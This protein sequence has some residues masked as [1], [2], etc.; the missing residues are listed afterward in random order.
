MD[1]LIPLSL[2]KEDKQFLLAANAAAAFEKANEAFQ[3]DFG[4]PIGLNSAYRSVE[5][6]KALYL[7]LRGKQA[8]APPG[9]SEHNYGR[10][11]DVQDW[12]AAKPYLE[13]VGFKWANHKND[14]W[15]YDFKGAGGKPSGQQ[16]QGALDVGMALPAPVD[17]FTPTLPTEGQLV[18]PAPKVPSILPA[19]KPIDI[20]PMLS[21]ATGIMGQSAPMPS[22]I[23]L[24]DPVAEARAQASS[25]VAT[26]GQQFAR[27][28]EPPKTNFV[29]DFFSHAANA[30]TGYTQDQLLQNS[31]NGIGSM[32]G[33]V[34]GGLVPIATGTAAG[35]GLGALSLTPFGVGAGAVGGGIASAGAASA[36]Q[37]LQAQR[38]EGTQ[39][40]NLLR[41]AGAAGV[42]ALTQ[43][44]PIIK[45]GSILS[46]LAKNAAVQG[47]AGGAGAIAQQGFEQGRIIPNVDWNRVGAQAALGAAGGTVGAGS[48]YA[49]PAVA[50]NLEARTD[51]RNYEAW[52]QS[53]EPFNRY[54]PADP[55]N[56]T[57]VRVDSGP[58]VVSSKTP[59]TQRFGVIDAAQVN[60]P[61]GQEVLYNSRKAAADAY[62]VVKAQDPNFVG[63]IKQT[64]DGAFVIH[65]R[66]ET[67]TAG[68]QV[69]PAPIKPDPIID[70]PSSPQLATEGSLTSQS[71][72]V[73]SVARGV[74]VL[75]APEPLK[76]RLP[77]PTPLVDAPTQPVQISEGKPFTGE[78]LPPKPIQPPEPQA[79]QTKVTPEQKS[80]I[81]TGKAITPEM[82]QPN[83][84]ATTAKVSKAFAEGK[85]VSTSDGAEVFVGKSPDK[86]QAALSDLSKASDE[87]GSMKLI[88]FNE[89]RQ[90]VQEYL[91]DKMPFF[92]AFWQAGTEGK[93]LIT[94]YR[95][96][97]RG[98]A[99][100]TPDDFMHR[101]AEGKAPSAESF[102][103]KEQAL[104]A[105]E[106]HRRINPTHQ[107][108]DPY[109]VT[110]TVRGK[111]K[112]KWQVD[113]VGDRQ[114]D[115][116]A[117]GLQEKNGEPYLYL[118]SYN[119]SSTK[120]GN[121]RGYRLG[122]MNET[123]DGFNASQI[124]ANSPYGNSIQAIQKQAN[125]L[126]QFVMDSLPTKHAIPLLAD[127]DSGNFP[128][129][130]AKLRKAM[131]GMNYEEAHQ[132]EAALKAICKL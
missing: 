48:E 91:P 122:R 68:G 19:P 12:E 52:L 101:Y 25:D 60:H 42:G 69:L 55:S 28:P 75:P 85:L 132:L 105:A 83:L 35:A 17:P 95:E 81:D 10:A 22:P 49:I 2:S 64:P 90:L 107:V 111:E 21:Q 15:H 106:A 56:P 82:T 58:V 89:G 38:L 20:T 115:P 5:E 36:A 16:P 3:M 92:E 117:I 18:V 66:N 13:A 45:G 125:E 34:A 72:D 31:G 23:R 128:A 4:R 50:K 127:V 129:A 87:G 1:G 14:P 86:T 97:V 124:D 6:Q 94:N 126:R 114:I 47:A 78:P 33:D 57:P 74:D 123:L 65:G 61:N 27:P 76:P 104:V 8:V 43:A 80:L 112:T 71:P 119:Y 79:I 98:W 9:R 99:K 131:K 84:E 110:V 62:N 70:S 108:S 54:V 44:I 103:T 26:V 32:L 40:P 100:G 77:E 130:G 37:D 29:G 120:K 51:T 118:M 46:T 30:A 93:Q 11:L 24:S 121:V 73:P 96:R 7:K 113:A 116:F 102:A 67:A 63:D 59:Q 41:A 109:P 88:G 39:N 53:Q